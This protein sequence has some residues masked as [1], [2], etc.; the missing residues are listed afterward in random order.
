M[1]PR[2][3][4]VVDDIP[5]VREFLFD[6]L[7]PRYEVTCIGTHKEALRTLDETSFD[8]LMVDVANDPTNI[9]LLESVGGRKDAPITIAVTGER[10]AGTAVRMMK[11]GVYDYIEKPFTVE[12]ILYTVEKAFEYGALQRQNRTL[13]EQMGQ[14]DAAQ[15]IVGI[16]QAIHALRE[17][18]RVVAASSADVLITGE[19]GT[20]KEVVAREIHRTSGRA[21][22]PFV[23]VVCSAIPELLLEAELFGSERGFYGGERGPMLGKFEKASGGTLLLEDVGEMTPSTQVNVLRAIRDG[24]ISREEGTESVHV[25]VRVIATT[26]RDLKKDVQRGVFRE[27]LYCRLNVAEI[28]LVPLRERREDIPLLVRHFIRNH[29]DGTTIRVT[30]AAMKKLCSGQ[31]RGNIRELENAIERAV[32][33]APGMILDEKHVEMSAEREEL[34]RIEETFRHG[35]VREMEKLMILFRLVEHDQNRTRA[36]KSLEISVRTVRN[37]LREYREAKIEVRERLRAR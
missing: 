16:S 5:E 18:V 9:E 23:K 27:D 36:A 12:R 15:S 37:K 30:E 2:K 28:G 11:I 33:T 31:W 19:G 7:K 8:V 4:L 34:S 25:D 26:K 1:N 21:R 10:A 32:I 35:S 6:A 17:R 24:L 3:L 13:E 29:T 22:Q 14:F 20:G